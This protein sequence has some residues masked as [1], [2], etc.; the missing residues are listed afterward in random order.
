M[1]GAGDCDGD[2][3]RH[4]DNFS[5][6]FNCISHFTLPCHCRK[7]FFINGTDTPRKPGDLIHLPKELCNTYKLLAENGAN[8][9]YAGTVADLIVDDLRDLGSIIT[10]NDLVS[11]E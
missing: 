2:E 3:M 7:S 11:Y 4:D 10:K 1:M 8:D 9:F 5:L 6:P